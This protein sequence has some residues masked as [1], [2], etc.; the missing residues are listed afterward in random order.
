MLHRQIQP[1]RNRWPGFRYQASG[2]RPGL[3]VD[4]LHQPPASSPADRRPRQRPSRSPASAARS[5]RPRSRGHTNCAWPCGRNVPPWLIRRN[6]CPC[7][8]TI[9]RNSQRA[10]RPPIRAHQHRPIG[11]DGRATL[12]HHP[13]PCAPPRARLPGRPDRPGHRNGAAAINHADRQP[14]ELVTERRGIDRAR[15]R[16]GRPQPD[17][18]GQ[19]RH[20]PGRHRQIDACAPGLVRGIPTPCVQAVREIGDRLP[21]APAARPKRWRRCRDHPP[22]YRRCQS[23]RAPR[24][25]PGVG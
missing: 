20:N 6:G 24:P 10:D 18:P 7:N 25:L 5:S 3:P 19:Q 11:R 15:D 22:T 17:D 9:R 1:F 16:G 23:A 21:L 14:H 12:A 13:Q 2:H 8:R 4:P